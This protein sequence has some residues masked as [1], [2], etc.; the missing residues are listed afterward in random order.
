[1]SQIVN[2]W[3][4]TEQTILRSHMEGAVTWDMYNASLDEI[5][6]MLKGVSH[7]VYFV[8]TQ[9]KD[10]IPP[11]GNAFPHIKRFYLSLPANVRLHIIEGERTLD[12]MVLMMYL[13]L[14]KEIW[15][16]PKFVASYEEALKII[17]RE[18]SVAT[19]PMARIPIKP[20]EEATTN[21]RPAD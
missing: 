17:N 20:P 8:Q 5:L 21:L 16:V 4:N 3:A 19:I 1:M 13:R 2:E 11:K 6:V 9:G 14:H 10:Y 15:L 12:K 7:P 18:R